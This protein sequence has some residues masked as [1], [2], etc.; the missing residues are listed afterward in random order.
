MN[1]FSLS[2][3]PLGKFRRFLFEAGCARTGTKGGHEKWKLPGCPRSIIIQT[4]IDPVPERV[5]R[6]ALLDMGMTRHEF[7]AIMSRI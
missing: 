6:S 4:H 2:N 3:I 1:T 5:V 7:V